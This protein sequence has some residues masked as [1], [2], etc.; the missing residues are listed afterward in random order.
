MCRLFRY[1]ASKKYVKIMFMYVCVDFKNQT[2]L[3]PIL[4]T[5]YMDIYRKKIISYLH[6]KSKRLADEEHAA[7]VTDLKNGGRIEKKKVRS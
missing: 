2:N 6:K 5:K 1:H 3:N 4:F 7:G